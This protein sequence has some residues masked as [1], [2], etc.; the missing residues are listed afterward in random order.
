MSRHQFPPTVYSLFLCG[1]DTVEIAEMRAIP[2]HEVIRR[3]TA[4]RASAK[5]L[6]VESRPS[7][8][9]ASPVKKWLA[10]D[11]PGIGRTGL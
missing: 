2:E 5:G 4:Q 6:P 9:R 11:H 8:Y 7:P 1:F 3:L 10:G